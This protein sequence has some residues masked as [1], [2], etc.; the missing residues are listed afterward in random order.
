MNYF[1]RRKTISDY[2]SSSLINSQK[3]DGVKFCLFPALIRLLHAIV[4]WIPS[5]SMSVYDG[6]VSVLYFVLTGQ[7]MPNKTE[8]SSL[9]INSQAAFEVRMIFL[10]L[11][12]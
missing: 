4:E 6:L 3:S 12:L 5:M 9:S 10:K 2:F 7:K 11:E 8:M 1:S